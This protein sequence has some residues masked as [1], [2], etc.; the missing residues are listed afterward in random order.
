[1]ELTKLFEIGTK[2]S[3]YV[4]ISIYNSVLCHFHDPS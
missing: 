3:A 4:Y 1:M 2:I